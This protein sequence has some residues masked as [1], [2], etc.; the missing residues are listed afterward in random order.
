MPSPVSS[1]LGL[2][3]LGQAAS[4]LTNC[5]RLYSKGPNYQRGVFRIS[6]GV[7]EGHFKGKSRREV[8]QG[9]LVLARQSHGA[10]GPCNPEETGLPVFPVSWPHTLFSGSSL[11]GLPP[12]PWT[13]RKQSKD[14][15]FSPCAEAIAAAETWLDGQPIEILRGLQK[16]EQRAKKCIELRGECVE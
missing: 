5:G 10:S 16:L 6:T 14:H 9:G 2:N 7:I 4:S 15:H 1:V 13:E 11:V 12:V 8:H 3:I